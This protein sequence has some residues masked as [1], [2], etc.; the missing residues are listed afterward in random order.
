MYYKRIKSL[1]LSKQ[2]KYVLCVIIGIVFVFYNGHYYQNVTTD[3]DLNLGN[4]KCILEHKSMYDSSC[5]G[6]IVYS[7]FFLMLYTPFGLLS[8]NIA[9]NIYLVLQ[10]VAILL[11]AYFF[12]KFINKPIFTFPICFIICI[13]NRPVIYVIRCLNPSI[14][15][16][17]LTIASLYFI[18]NTTNSLSVPKNRS[19]LFLSIK[20]IGAILLGVAIVFKIYPVLFIILLLVYKK[21]KEIIIVC[22]TGII[23]TLI[24]WTLFPLDTYT[25]IFK[26]VFGFKTV[27]LFGQD[28]MWNI[29][30]NSLFNN[31]GLTS[32]LWSIIKYAIILI[33]FIIITLHIKKL[34]IYV[35]I[36]LLTAFQ[37]LLAP[38]VWEH[39]LILAI[40]IPFI[41]W[42]STKNKQILW[43]CVTFIIFFTR[44]SLY[45]HQLSFVPPIFWI[46]NST[47]LCL[48]FCIV[49]PFQLAKSKKLKTTNQNLQSL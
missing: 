10:L 29:S 13:I 9:I 43:T 34:P 1:F 33:A 25:Y 16:A 20:N 7:P 2:F 12:Y 15:V 23:C 49:L 24:G 46:F 17:L 22:I 45:V 41:Y 5:N 14:F 39:H 48:Y 26:F 8:Q 28:I 21:Y 31:L 44:Y 6:H 38:T 36:C 4:V 19:N 27:Q 18:F 30:L 35:S 3:F 47:V 40:F 11:I 42:C 32:L 37:C